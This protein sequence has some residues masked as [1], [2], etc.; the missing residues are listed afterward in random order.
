MIPKP[1]GTARVALRAVLASMAAISTL[2][3]AQTVAP[4]PL[5]TGDTG[6]AA[7]FPNDMNIRS[8]ADVLFA[9]GFETYTSPSQFTSSGS[10]TNYWQTS[11]VVLD[12][13][14]F[15]SGTKAVRLRMPAIGGSYGNGVEKRNFPEQDKL[16]ARFYHRFQADYEGVRDAHNGLVISGRYPGPG[17]RPNGSDFFLV[18]VENSRYL[19]EAEPGYTH[20][21]VYHPEQDDSYGEHW[22]PDGTVSNGTQ[23]F[24][25]YFISRPRLN[26][27]RGVWV[28]TEIMVQLNTP[29]VRDGRVAIW[30]DGKLIA[31]WLNLR[32]RDVSTVRI[33]TISMGNGGK[34]STQQND[35]W[36]DNLVL[37]TSYVGP[38]STGLASSPPRPPKSLRIY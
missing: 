1:T 20:A 2:A 15:F 6:I 18:L 14:M 36:Y 12:T 26:L 11:T 30:Q 4:P 8:H 13:A 3:Y 35:K 9:D 7:S 23:N 22:Y 34:S 38:M 29:G 31:D 37:A 24:G 19:N 10:Y 25:P 28:C 16:F 5:P 33:D 27:P 17:I 21:Y 32:F